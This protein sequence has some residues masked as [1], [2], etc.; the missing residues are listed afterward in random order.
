MRIDG[1]RSTPKYARETYAGWWFHCGIRRLRRG[2]Y[3]DA[4]VC[5][6]DAFTFTT[7][8]AR[9]RAR[10]LWEHAGR[11]HTLAAALPTI[12]PTATEQQHATAAARIVADM[13]GG[14][15]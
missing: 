15:A 4:R 13:N 1:Q 5:F 2:E 12:N 14:A 9:R 8:T 3:L 10:R 6:A 11:M 7:P